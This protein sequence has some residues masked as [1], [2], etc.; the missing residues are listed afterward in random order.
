[1]DRRW[2]V[3]ETIYPLINVIS[4]AQGADLRSNFISSLVAS[5]SAKSNRARTSAARNGNTRWLMMARVALCPAVDCQII[6]NIAKPT[7]SCAVARHRA[8]T[9]RIVEQNRKRRLLPGNSATRSNETR[10]PIF[11][12]SHSRALTD[13]HRAPTCTPAFRVG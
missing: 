12:F 13:F 4:F 11:A 1:M 8:R 5:A 7:R 10:R 2:V 6:D 3:N 9:M